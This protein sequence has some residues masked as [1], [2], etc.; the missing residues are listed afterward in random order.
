M[1]KSHD[2]SIQIPTHEGI[3]IGFYE[4]TSLG[5]P[6]ITLNREPHN[7]VVTSDFTGWLLPA[8]PFELPDN[9]HGVVNAGKLEVDSLASFLVKLSF[10]EVTEVK[11]RTQEFYLK[12]Y[13]NIIFKTRLLSSLGS[14]KMISP[15]QRSVA[16]KPSEIRYRK[17]F[18]KFLSFCRRYLIKVIPLSINQKYK[19]KQFLLFID[20][21]IS[22]RLK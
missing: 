6:V 18:N 4:S 19:I 11:L 13:S 15:K 5:V 14:K 22:S 21:K 20:Q 12:N 3:G 1:Y 8:T 10:Q 2:V 17:A 16:M 7:E 9:S